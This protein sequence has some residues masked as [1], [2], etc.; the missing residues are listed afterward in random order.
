MLFLSQYTET[1][2]KY[3][4]LNKFKYKSTQRMPK[5][6][7]II[8]NFNFNKG[9]VKTLIPLMAALKLITLQDSKI[10]TSSVSNISFKIRKGQPVGC[11]LKLKKK[12]AN[13]LLFILLN[14][15]IPK[16]KIIK[17]NGN[18]FSF[19]LNNSLIFSELEKNYKFF[20]KLPTLNIH[21]KFSKCNANEFQCLIKSYKLN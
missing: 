15:I 14:N 19:K 6:E 7:Y 10:T 5:L 9:E 20:K 1:V 18:M 13:N 2:V 12:R 17:L 11:T 3:D 4:L 16:K 8:L 21:I